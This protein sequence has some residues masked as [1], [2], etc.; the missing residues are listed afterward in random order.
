M[1]TGVVHV[2]T[3]SGS[4]VT[5]GP[6]LKD[7][8]SCLQGGQAA[9]ARLNV[10]YNWIARNHNKYQTLDECCSQHIKYIRTR[11]SHMLRI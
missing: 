8:G 2:W 11:V 1:V 10:L 3:L 4:L 6:S 5:S 9:A 7:G